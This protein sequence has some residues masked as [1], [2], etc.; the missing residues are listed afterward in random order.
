[1]PLPKVTA[2]SF[3]LTCVLPFVTAAAADDSTCSGRVGALQPPRAE[4][5]GAADRTRLKGC[6]SVLLYYGTEVFPPNP[7][8]ARLCAY[9]ELQADDDGPSV[10]PASILMALY[11][12]GDGVARNPD[13]ARHFAC[14]LGGNAGDSERIAQRLDESTRAGKRVDPCDATGAWPTA[15]ICF[16]YQYGGDLARAGR[17]IAAI[18]ARWPATQQ[19]VFVPLKAAADAY[20]RNRGHA[21]INNGDPSDT[22][23][24]FEVGFRQEFRDALKAVEGS[25]PLGEGDAAA[26]DRDLNAAYRK[27]MK[28]V[29][30]VRADNGM[31]FA[32]L[33]VASLRDVERSWL[34]YVDAWE[35][36]RMMAYPHVPAERLRSM[37]VRQRT[38]ALAAMCGENELDCEE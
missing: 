31:V 32:N 17:D 34:A 29:E 24:Y 21:E 20:E 36:F 26:L 15:D 37:L 22:Q 8:D 14:M 30:Q 38:A 2:L 18:A 19:K 9:I 4:L 5:P 1:M 11:A 35:H 33:T 7:G 3:L 23:L 25:A 27:V 28:K 16:G 6:E 13:M 10:P 12:N